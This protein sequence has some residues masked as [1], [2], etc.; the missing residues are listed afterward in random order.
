MG[1]N[2]T[3]DFNLD[4]FERCVKNNEYQGAVKMIV[5]HE[6]LTNNFIDIVIKYNDFKLMKFLAVFRIEMV[7][8]YLNNNSE[9]TDLDLVKFLIE[10]KIDGID[11]LKNAVD[12][13]QH[14]TYKYLIT[15]EEVKIK[16]EDVLWYYK[17]AFDFRFNSPFSCALLKYLISNKYHVNSDEHKNKL[18]MWY[19]RDGNIDKVK[20]LIENGA[21]IKCRNYY[22][23]RWAVWENH[24]EIVELCRCQCK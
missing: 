17:K 11:Y 10:S 19:A 12:N 24:K 21:N 13:N 1:S 23:L 7:S 3:S 6:H 22:A 5:N 4:K 8:N 9:I 16:E 20:E 15:Q 18:L 14:E 2:C